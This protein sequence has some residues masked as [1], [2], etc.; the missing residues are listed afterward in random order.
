MSSDVISTSKKRVSGIKKKKR[1][2]DSDT[3]RL[4]G[5]ASTLGKITDDIDRLCGGG[6]S[7][8]I[9]LRRELDIFK[10]PLVLEE[11]G[12]CPACLH[13][14][15]LLGIARRIDQ[16]KIVLNNILKS[17][18]Q[19]K[20]YCTQ[21]GTS[22]D[23]LKKSVDVF[24][25]SFITHYNNDTAGARKYEYY[26]QKRIAVEEDAMLPTTKKRKTEQKYAT[27][28]TSLA[29]GPSLFLREDAAAAEPRTR[30]RGK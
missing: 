14:P 13:I 17:S 8:S 9:P 4:K 7:R 28:A 20:Q 27:S 24:V 21:L 6:A 18:R 2:L 23:E 16:G 26:M 12:L 1:A 15:Q 22:L 30:K 19:A 25:D 5:Q 11:I 3:S 10:E 29:E